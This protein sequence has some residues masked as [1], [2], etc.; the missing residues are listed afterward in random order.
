MTISSTGPLIF[1]TDLIQS[2]DSHSPSHPTT[3]EWYS[4]IRPSRPF[5]SVL[6][7]PHLH[8]VECV[9]VVGLMHLPPRVTLFSF[10]VFSALGS[11]GR[12]PSQ[13][14]P[15]P[16]RTATV[17]RN[18]RFFRRWRAIQYNYFK[19]LLT[20]CVSLGTRIE[21]TWRLSH[22]PSAPFLLDWCTRARGTPRTLL[23][24]H[25]LFLNEFNPRSLEA[26]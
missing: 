6:W 25:H 4:S 16:Y 21:C 11:F 19:F 1:R 8:P 5:P 23:Y 10:R 18:A 22:V 20:F 17:Y 12:I 13:R 15:E 14:P 7:L 26:H 24:A 3:P 2:A 9:Y